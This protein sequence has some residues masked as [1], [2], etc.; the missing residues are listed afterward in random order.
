M[1]LSSLSTILKKHWS[2]GS[3]GGGGGGVNFVELW[4]MTLVLH[5]Q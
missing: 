2:L 3:G 4:T 1:T 5:V